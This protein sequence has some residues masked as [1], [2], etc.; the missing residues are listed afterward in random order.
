MQGTQGAYVTVALLGQALSQ[1][2]VPQPVQWDACGVPEL[3]FAG[4]SDPGSITRSDNSSLLQMASGW[5]SP[6]VHGRGCELPSQG[7]AAV[8]TLTSCLGGL[9]ACEDWERFQ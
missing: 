4:V 1:A 5:R 7:E 9:Q 2:S 3:G 8:Q 6:G